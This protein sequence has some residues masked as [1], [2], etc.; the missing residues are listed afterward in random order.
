M[1]AAGI[2]LLA[3]FIADRRLNT[4]G[5]A[6]VPAGLIAIG[7]MWYNFARFGSVT[8][9]GH[10]YLVS[11]APQFHDSGFGLAHLKHNLW[12]YFVS[13]PRVTASFP[14]LKDC[15]DVDHENAFGLLTCAPA[16]AL[17]GLAFLDM[18]RPLRWL[19]LGMGLSMAALIMAIS[20]YQ[21]SSVRYQAEFSPFIFVL[22]AIG[23]LIMEPFGMKWFRQLWVWLLVVSALFNLLIAYRLQ[24]EAWKTEAYVALN[25]HHDV[26]RAEECYRKCLAIDDSHHEAHN[27]YGFLLLQ[28]GRPFEAMPHFARALELTPDWPEPRIHYAQALL[29]T[30][31]R[32]AACGQLDLLAS[33]DTNAAAQVVVWKEKI[34]RG[35][36]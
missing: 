9:F 33:Y 25:L 14:F 22:V 3:P 2:V 34:R 4:V 24:G 20:A 18:R 10:L 1:A 28:L 7:L 27:Q 12:H 30:G 17:C 5:A 19:A 21:G 26:A 15:A 6:F 29:M 35:L 31:Q 23:V 13:L 11:G 36:Q 16:A 8:E 32:E